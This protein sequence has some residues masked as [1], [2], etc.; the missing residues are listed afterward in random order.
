MGGG[1]TKP[2]GALVHISPSGDANATGIYRAISAKDAMKV[3]AEDDITTL[4]EAFKYVLRSALFR[5]SQAAHEH[6]PSKGPFSSARLILSSSAAPSSASRT[7]STSVG[8]SARALTSGCRTA[9]RRPAPV[10]LAAA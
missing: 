1:L 4:Y 10:T 6:S 9:W 7:T 2:E 8:V 3:R 5:G